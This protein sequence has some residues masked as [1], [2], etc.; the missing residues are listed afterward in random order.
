M[1]ITI[2]FSVIL[3]YSLQMGSTLLIVDTKMKIFVFFTKHRIQ[4][5]S[6]SQY[7]DFDIL[8]F[9]CTT[10]W[11]PHSTFV[12]CKKFLQVWFLWEI[13]PQKFRIFTRR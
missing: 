1:T 10:F 13:K 4:M 7:F 5:S 3:V 8:D 11:I 6:Q 12:I 9:V 2:G